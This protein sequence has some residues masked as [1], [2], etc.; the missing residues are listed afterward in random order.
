M[1]VFLWRAS[2]FFVRKPS[3][4]M[5]S[6]Q[7]TNRKF[8]RWQQLWKRSAC[9][10]SAVRW[11]GADLLSDGKKDSRA[12]DHE[13]NFYFLSGQQTKVNDN[14]KTPKELRSDRNIWTGGAA[15][16][17]GSAGSWTW[18]S[19]CVHDSFPPAEGL[20]T[21]IRHFY[22]KHAATGDEQEDPHRL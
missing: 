6:L 16:H 8:L 22:S 15:G 4:R 1:F 7:W 11:G 12:K 20:I 13:G 14:G 17:E 9:F 18:L 2:C 5:S 10:G 3:S 19:A 21:N